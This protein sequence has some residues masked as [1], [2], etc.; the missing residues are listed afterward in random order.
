MNLPSGVSWLVR[1]GFHICA[2]VLFRE[3]RSAGKTRIQPPLYVVTVDSAAGRCMFPE[4]G[5]GRAL[6]YLEY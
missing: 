3:I 4:G 5:Q 2:R 1:F 6:S